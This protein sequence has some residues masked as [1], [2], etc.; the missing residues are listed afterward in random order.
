MFKKIVLKLFSNKKIEI[1]YSK[2]SGRGVF[3]NENIFER[4][5]LE[6][7]HHVV[8]NEQLFHQDISIQPYLFL[9]PYLENSSSVVFGVGSIFNH[10]NKNNAHWIVDRVRNLYIFYATKN[11]SKGDEIF[12]D[13]G[14]LYEKFVGT[15]IGIN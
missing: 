11:I 13:Y 14:I 9:W 6:E 15:N 4:E 2:I 3:A 10:S 8:L 7:C 5:I 1:K 12:I